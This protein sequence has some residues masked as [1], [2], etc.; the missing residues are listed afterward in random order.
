MTIE[1]IAPILGS[2]LLAGT[3]VHP[4]HLPERF[5]LCTLI[6][7]GEAIVSVVSGTATT[8]WQL[9][10][11]LAAVGGFVIAAC[12][13]W[14]YFNFLETSVVIRDIRSVHIYNYGHLPI[15]IGLI[16][17]A[18]GIQHTIEEANYNML[19][20]A[21][22]WALCGGVELYIVALAI[23]RLTAARSS[24][25]WFPWFLGSAVAIPLGLAVAG[26]GLTPLALEGSL[27]TVLV[28]KVGL[29]IWQVTEAS[30]K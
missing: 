30:L 6:I 5:G 10:S 11:V 16:L 4:S 7:L 13:F 1:L 20:T 28:A 23:I 29:E 8:N 25:T 3:P 17:V 9:S 15:L 22:R 12:L 27:L 19:P 18:V 2:R 24:V 21:T 26:D 14:T